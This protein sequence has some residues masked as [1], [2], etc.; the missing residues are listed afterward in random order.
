[1][2]LAMARL[3]LDDRAGY[4]KACARMVELALATEDRTAA[5]MAALTC[6]LEA[7]AVPQ[8]DAVGRLAARAAEGYDGDSRIHV[9]ALLRAGRVAEALERPWSQ[10][11]RYT[12]IVWEWLFQGMLRLRA[13]RHAEALSIL[14]EEFKETDYLDQKEPRDPESEIWS[15][16]IYHVQC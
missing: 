1:R 9:A 4:Q 16:W 7:G 8:W 5:Q 10:E 13:G 2:D 3:A 6:V 15:D 12:H 14:E 11:T